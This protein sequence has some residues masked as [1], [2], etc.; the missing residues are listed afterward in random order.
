VPRDYTI[1]VFPVKNGIIQAEP[2]EQWENR[3]SR[4][5]FGNAAME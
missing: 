1:R 4:R 5:E 3:V 2:I